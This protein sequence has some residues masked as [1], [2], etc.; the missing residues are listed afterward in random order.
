MESAGVMLL[1]VLAL[2]VWFTACYTVVAFV[3]WDFAWIVDAAAE[4]RAAFL[5][6]SALVGVFIILGAASQ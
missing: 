6:V 4:A 2:T 1:F 3:T 5:I